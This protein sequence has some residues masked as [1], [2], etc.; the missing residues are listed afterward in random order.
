MYCSNIYIYKLK[1]NVSVLSS[2]TVNI[3]VAHWK[4]VATAAH[5][6]PSLCCCCVQQCC[7][8]YIIQ[9]YLLWFKE[10]ILNHMDVART[11][12]VTCVFILTK[13]WNSII[14]SQLNIVVRHEH[15]QNGCSDGNASLFS[16]CHV[17]NTVT[18]REILTYSANLL[19]WHLVHHRNSIWI[20]LGFNQ[21]SAVKCQNKTVWNMSQ[22]LVT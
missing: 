7:T 1:Y 15:Q 17:L 9:A 18:K 14:W 3:N 6:I 16:F 2:V 19:Q 8:F 21:K 20:A 13:S 5:R 11:L 12:C 22:I 4:R 10:Q